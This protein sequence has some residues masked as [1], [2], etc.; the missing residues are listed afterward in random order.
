MRKKNN[1]PSEAEM[2]ILEYVWKESRPLSHVD[3]LTH[4]N[5]SGKDWKKQTINTFVQ[6]LMEKGYLKK[7][8]GRNKRSFLYEASMTKDEY[9]H[10]LAYHVVNTSFGGSIESFIKHYHN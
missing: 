5:E 10:I 1:F 8:P 2:E 4:F 3:F 9:L 7:I 6:R